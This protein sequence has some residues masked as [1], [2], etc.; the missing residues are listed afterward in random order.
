[1]RTYAKY[2]P[3]ERQSVSYTGPITRSTTGDSNGGCVRCSKESIAV[4]SQA[5]GELT[6]AYCL[7]TERS[8]PLP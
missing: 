4:P 3:R 6:G 7:S 1:M 5:G 8:N 2:P